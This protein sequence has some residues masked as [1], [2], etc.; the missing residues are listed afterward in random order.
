M[1]FFFDEMLQDAEVKKE[2]APLRAESGFQLVRDMIKTSHRNKDCI[3]HGQETGYNLRLI[4]S[5]TT[6]ID[7]KRPGMILSPYYGEALFHRH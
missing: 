1:L 5:V 6:T 4:Y 2:Y 7:Y 3:G